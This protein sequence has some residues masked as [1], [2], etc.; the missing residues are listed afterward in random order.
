MIGFELKTDKD[1]PAT[2]FKKDIS[3]GHDHLEWME[4]TYGDYSSL[5]LVYIGPDGSVD[6]KANPSDE[7]GLCLPQSVGALRDRVIALIEDL[8]K[9]TPIER[10]TIISKITEEKRWDIEALLDEFWAKDMTDL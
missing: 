10:L 3:Q 1:D 9:E 8:R 2:Y 5:G 6:A 7:M 4:Q